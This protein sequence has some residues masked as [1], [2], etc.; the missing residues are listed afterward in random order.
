MTPAPRAPWYVMPCSDEACLCVTDS[1]RDTTLSKGMI[2]LVRLH[3]SS[4]PLCPFV[5]SDFFVPFPGFDSS[6][7]HLLGLS[8]DR[9]A[10]LEVAD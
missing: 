6:F 4:R 2:D 10:H 3:A 7:S 5:S 9:C 8:M 1:T